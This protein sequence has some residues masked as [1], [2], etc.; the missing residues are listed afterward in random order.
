MV[1]QP[2][3][4][5][6]EPPPHDLEG[7][8]E[9]MKRDVLLVATAGASLLNGMHFSP[10]FDPVAILLRPFIAG[11]FLGTPLLSLYLTSIFI[12]VMTLLIAGIPVAIYERT[13]ALTQSNATSLGIWLAVTL[14]LTVPSLIGLLGSR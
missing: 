4:P 12:S 8:E 13:K 2:Q 14:L 7:R 5:P 3:V 1:K 10:F 6:P 9:M 11:T